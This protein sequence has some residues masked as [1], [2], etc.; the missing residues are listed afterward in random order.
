[1]I[2]L[3]THPR[4]IVRMLD[5]EGDRATWWMRKQMGGDNAVRLQ[6]SDMQDRIIET[7][8]DRRFSDPYYYTSREGNRWIAYLYA[9]KDEVY[10]HCIQQAYPYRFTEGSIECYAPHTFHTDEGAEMRGYI[11]YTSHFFRRLAERLTL[12]A[13]DIEGIM[14]RFIRL[15]Y[16]SNNYMAEFKPRTG[17]RDAEVAVSYPGSYALGTFRDYDGIRAVTMRTFIPAAMIAPR[18]LKQIR[19]AFA[20]KEGHL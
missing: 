7:G 6:M 5:E 12:D 18:R 11:H 8:D 16:S 17:Y 2:T 14:Q 9:Y 10:V 13:E 1:M 3:D 19:K 15:T 4:E 20:G